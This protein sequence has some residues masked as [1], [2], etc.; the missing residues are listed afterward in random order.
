MKFVVTIKLSK[1]FEQITVV[2]HIM[3]G[4]GD[5]DDRGLKYTEVERECLSVG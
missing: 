2:F 5:T 1:V 3:N 4:A